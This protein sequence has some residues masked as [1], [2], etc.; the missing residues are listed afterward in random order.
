[1]VKAGSEKL[2]VKKNKPLACLWMI[3][4]DAAQHG[5]VRTGAVLVC[6]ADVLVANQAGFSVHRLGVHAGEL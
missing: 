3:E 2:F 1:M 5:W 4:F 6:K